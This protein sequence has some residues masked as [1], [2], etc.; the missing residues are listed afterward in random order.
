MEGLVHWR[1]TMPVEGQLDILLAD[2]ATLLFTGKGAQKAATKS[3]K[4]K[5]AK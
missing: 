2:V 5:S 4:R 3:E 1:L